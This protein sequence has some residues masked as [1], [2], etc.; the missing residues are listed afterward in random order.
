MLLHKWRKR[1][2]K[3]MVKIM[4]ETWQKLEGNIKMGLKET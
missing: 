1:E 4:K 2:Y 3:V